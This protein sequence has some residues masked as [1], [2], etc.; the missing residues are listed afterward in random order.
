MKIELKYVTL[1]S[2]DE[3]L[4]YWFISHDFA[5]A[6]GVEYSRDAAR[7]LKKAIGPK[8]AR[9][10]YE[11]D[12]VI[13]RISRGENV[14]PTLTAIYDRLGWDKAELA[15]VAKQVAVFKRPRRRKIAVGDVFLIPLGADLFGLGQVLDIIYTAPTVAVF[16]CLG[17]ADDLSENDISDCQAL[18]ILHIHG[19]SLYKGDWRVIGTAPVRLDPASGPGR[20][21]GEVGSSSWGRDGPITHLL[22]AHAGRRPWE[23]GYQDPTY[24][25]SLVLVKTD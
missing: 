6:L 1:H 8:L 23:L 25:R 16:T 22:L 10:D 9:I 5:E 24:L 21:L 7:A 18:T 3:L 13:V 17:T 19:N 14:I 20:K 12:V 15:D 11:A 4:A 2:P